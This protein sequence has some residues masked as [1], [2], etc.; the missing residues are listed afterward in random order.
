MGSVD[1]SSLEGNEGWRTASFDLT[2]FSTAGITNGYLCPYFEAE[3]EETTINIDQI[4]IFDAVNNNLEASLD[5]PVRAQAGKSANIVVMVRNLGLAAANNY[6]VKAYV[7]NKLVETQEET[8]ALAAGD[9]KEYEFAY[10]PSLNEKSFV[11]FGEVEWDADQLQDNNVTDEAVIDVTFSSLPSV[12]D[13]AAT[14]S[15]SD[16]VLTWSEKNT[17]NEEVTET[18]DNYEP[19]ASA[20]VGDWTLYD[21]DKAA[22]YTFGGISFQG[23]GDPMSYVVFNPY[24]TTGLSGSILEQFASIFGAH[25]GKQYMASSSATIDTGTA[26]SDWII[27]P[28]LGRR[29][30]CIVLCILSE[31]RD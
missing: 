5:V 3:S 30:D 1:Y 21:G 22:T 25:S 20:K 17:E 2:E 10:T 31:R 16:A 19:F 24:A 23:M 15:G 11:A 27:T 7:N 26:T 9:T 18:F 13:L 12:D 4:R 28:E 29:A 8:E 6:K 14:M